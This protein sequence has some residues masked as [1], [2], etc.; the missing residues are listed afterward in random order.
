MAGDNP[1]GDCHDGNNA[2]T[3]GTP[4]D[5]WTDINWHTSRLLRIDR[6]PYS[7]HMCRLSYS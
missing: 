2:D 6:S 4:L 7:F 3:N 5:S 1:C